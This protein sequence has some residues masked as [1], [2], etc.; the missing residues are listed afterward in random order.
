MKIEE[1]TEKTSRSLLLE[2]VEHH[3]K[4]IYVHQHE[5]LAMV[6]Q[7]IHRQGH[8]LVVLSGVAT[9]NVERS[10]YYIPYGYFVWIPPGKS[11]RVSFEEKKIRLLNVYY[12]PEFANCEFYQE[13][14]VYPMPSILY[15]VIELI[16]GSTE[17][18]LLGNWKYELLST[19]NHILPHIIPTQRF[20]LRLP[21]SDHP[22]IQRILETIQRDYQQELTAQYVAEEVGLSVRTLSRYLRSELDV[23]FVQ[24]V[25]TYRILM[26]IKKMVKAEDSITNIAY[27]VGYDSLTAFSNSFYKVTGTRP[28][29]FLK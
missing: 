22:V 28:S 16:E 11:H 18:Y 10:A 20:Q 26:A 1:I 4:G 23:S 7:H 29:L 17:E 5:L 9:V 21:T 27:S 3:Q 24:Y 12:P 13:V 8:I 25:R 2:E 19:V 6:P 15:H 14:G